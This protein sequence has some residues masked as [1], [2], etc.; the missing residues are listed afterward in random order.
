MKVFYTLIGLL[1]CNFT[2]AQSGNALLLEGSQSYLAI[3]PNDSL[4]YQNGFTLSA[5]IF[6]VCSE[7]SA[8]MGKQ[9]CRDYGYY[10]GLID[11]KPYWSYNDEQY[12]TNP[13]AIGATEASVAAPGWYH[14]TL[15]HENTAIS[16]YVNGERVATERLEGEQSAIRQSGEPLV[17]GA[18]RFLDGYYGNFYSGLLD[19]VRM[20]Q[21]ILDDQEVGLA[22]RSDTLVRPEQLVLNLTMEDNAVGEVSVVPNSLPGGSAMVARALGRRKPQIMPVKKVNR[23]LYDRLAVEVG[24]SKQASRV[25]GRVF[26]D[27]NENGIYDAGEPLLPNVPVKV[28]TETTRWLYTDGTGNFRFAVMPDTQYVV[29]ADPPACLV[30]QDKAYTVY[31]EQELTEP[32]RLDL[33][34]VRGG[35]QGEFI[36]SIHSGPARCGFEVPFS[37]SLYN[38]GC[39]ADGAEVEL[40][41]DSLVSVTRVETDTVASGEQKLVWTAA[42]IAP[43]T[44][45]RFRFH[46]RMPSEDFVG[47]TLHFTMYSRST[48]PE[49]EWDTLSLDVVLAC[50]IDPNDKL[51]H[52][53]RLE[54][55][56]SNY[57]QFDE[58]ITYTIRFQNTG[59][60]PAYTVR[61]A[62]TLSELLDLRTFLPL[63]ASHEHSVD[64]DAAGHLTV[65]YENIDLPDS[66]TNEAASHGYFTFSIL[67]RAGVTEGVVENRAGIYF[68]YNRPIITNTVRNTLVETL[69]ADHDGFLFYEDCNDSDP[70]VYPGAVD[71]AGNGTDENCDGKD[72]TVATR[73]PGAAGLSLYPNPTT[74][75]LRLRDVRP[76]RSWAY[77]LFA[78]SG[79]RVSSGR[80]HGNDGTLELTA[81]PSGTYLLVLREIGGQSVVRQLITLQPK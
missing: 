40:V 13:N 15:V 12:C 58:R 68:D 41:L 24:C 27:R 19:D 5:W 20:W 38:N 30:T 23:Q 65:L 69:D 62:D 50:A 72:K 67:P 77:S 21:G 79:S 11:Q 4:D 29:S 8:I 63:S 35:K 22:M 75:L 43:G 61:L 28:E 74:G 73:T 17:I 49:A 76:D 71:I 32:I 3:D 6:P 39:L 9:H 25:I 33:P 81:H 66:T 48:A 2:Y 34:A 55:S 10:L 1:L 51:T 53:A 52:P 46:A 57:T 26:E 7:R 64:L 45:A 56:E 37:L 16:V 54:P 18:Y 31:T 80:V 14:L 36:T 47:D 59:T 44:A 78:V 42:N 60:A 70:K